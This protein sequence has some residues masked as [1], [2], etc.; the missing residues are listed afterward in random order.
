[1]RRAKEKTMTQMDKVWSLELH[2][3][4]AILCRKEKD[5]TTNSID[6]EGYRLLQ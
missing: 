5:S 6:L 1:M 2:A 4:L 3:S